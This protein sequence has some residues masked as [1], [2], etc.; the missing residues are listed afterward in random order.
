M[1]SNGR[2]S[3]SR[4]KFVGMGDNRSGGDLQDWRR[5]AWLES[6]AGRSGRTCEQM[7]SRAQTHQRRDASQTKRGICS[8]TVNCWHTQMQTVH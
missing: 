3:L 1:L 6:T 5:G 8:N 4:Q 2:P 7:A